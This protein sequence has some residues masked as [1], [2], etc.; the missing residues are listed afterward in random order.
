MKPT[1]KG[2][3][4]IPLSDNELMQIQAETLYVLNDNKIISINEPQQQTNTPLLFLGKTRTTTFKY[5]N[6]AIP[7]SLIEEVNQLLQQDL[8][9]VLLCNTLSTYKTPE[10]IWIGP[11]YSIPELDF[12]IEDKGIQIITESNRHYLTPYFNNV[13]E[14]Y[15]YRSPVIAFVDQGHAVS[16]CCSARKSDKAIEASLYTIEA[17][18]GKGIAARL[19]AYWSTYI[20]NLGYIPLYSTS[21]DNLHSQ[22]VAQKLGFIQYGVDFSISGK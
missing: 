7:Q 22:G 20:R 10:N 21:W 19:V 1:K 2:V 15:E 14:E 4:T 18:R 12:P 5:F 16:V 3:T 9:I 17:Y 6:T 13:N 8:N 11:A